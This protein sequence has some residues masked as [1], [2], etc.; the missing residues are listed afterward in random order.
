VKYISFLRWRVAL[1]CFQRTLLVCCLAAASPLQAVVFGCSNCANWW[2]QLIQNQQLIKQHV[3]QLRQL[4]AQIETLQN[5][6]R[7]AQRLGTFIHHQDAFDAINRV[8]ALTWDNQQAANDLQQASR[9]IEE[10]YQ[11]QRGQKAEG[12]TY[13]ELYQRWSERNARQIE[14]ARRVARLHN[15]TLAG[16]Q[17]KVEYV[18]TQLRSSEG[19]MQALQAAGEIAQQ[20]LLQLQKLNTL[21][22]AQIQFN[23]DSKAQMAEKEDVRASERNRFLSREG[24][25]GLDL[26]GQGHRAGQEFRRSPQ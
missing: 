23:A 20:Q 4:R 12:L 19:M 21:L 25:D 15:Q 24:V 6:A 2:E 22:A 3:T 26:T 18:S 7:N 11:G 5:A 16:D 8:H 10:A 17:K 9:G 14:Q 13:S 1:R